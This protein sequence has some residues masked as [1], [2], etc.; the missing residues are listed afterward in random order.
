MWL[1][2]S[3]MLID[4]VCICL[5][6][7]AS[8]WWEDWEGNTSSQFKYRTSPRSCNRVSGAWSKDKWMLMGWATSTNLPEAPG[9]QVAKFK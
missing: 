9:I 7:G 4:C 8:E 5:L 2:S 6:S 3:N 1:L